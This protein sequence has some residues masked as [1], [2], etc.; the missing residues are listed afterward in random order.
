MENGPFPYT[1]LSLVEFVDTKTRFQ[2]IRVFFSM[3]FMIFLH[4]Y[5]LIILPEDHKTPWSQ[6]FHDYF[7][8]RVLFLLLGLI[9]F[10]FL[11]H[12]IGVII[13]IF[14]QLSSSTLYF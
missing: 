11:F 13:P 4:S 5:I 12:F 14:T 9:F 7:A 1:I 10:C 3:S 6:K 2:I 8:M